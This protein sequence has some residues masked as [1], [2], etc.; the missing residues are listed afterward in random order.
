MAPETGP[1][2]AIVFVGGCWEGEGGKERGEKGAYMRSEK[3]VLV[4]VSVQSGSR[5]C[6]TSTSNPK[7]GQRSVAWGEDE[8]CKTLDQV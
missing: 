1:F 5:C 2:D 4:L 7:Y 3:M 8:N 6:P